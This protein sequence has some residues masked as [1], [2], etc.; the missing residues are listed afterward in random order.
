MLLGLLGIVIVVV[1]VVL[2]IVT[3]IVAVNTPY[4]NTRLSLCQAD[5]LCHLGT[6]TRLSLNFKDQK[7]PYLVHTDVQVKLN[8]LF[9][10]LML[11]FEKHD[12]NSWLVKSSLLGYVR[13]G[14]RVP[15]CDKFEIAIWHD[16]LSKLVGLRDELERSSDH[17][18]QSDAHG[19]R[20]SCKN[21]A[22]FPFVSINLMKETDIEVAVCTPLDEL[23]ACSYSDSYQ[24]RREVFATDIIKP[25]QAIKFKL[26][27]TSSPPLEVS[28]YSVNEEV[29]KTEVNV[30]VPHEPERCLDVLYG[31][32][33]STTV[34]QS[35]FIHF[36]N[37]Y[38]RALTKR[39]TNY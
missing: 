3:V 12:I 19:Y 39:L 38:T 5:Q 33:W 15:W 30:N 35:K 8:E 29:E 23:S 34:T 27:V 7:R 14:G 13:H 36:N 6:G 21:T 22:R 16:E 28:Q 26:N 37:S 2:S 18:L 31:P 24:R 32:D 25:L 10:K 1:L 11:A 9:T 20:F 4:T 17:V